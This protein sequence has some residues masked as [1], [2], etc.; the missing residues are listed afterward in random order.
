ME[1]D[2]P[3][4]RVT[5]VEDRAEDEVAEVYVRACGPLIGLLTVMGGSASEAEEVAQEAF[6]RLLVNW[7]RVREYDDIDA[8]LRLVA[9][10]LLV[11]RHRRTKVARLGLGR[12]AA[13]SAQ[14]APE[15][16]PDALDLRQALSALP[17]GSRAVLVLHH[18][19]DLPVSEI[20]SLLRV[21]VGTV[22]SRLA[23]ARAAIAPLLT[24]RTAP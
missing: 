10:R 14:V 8:W 20:A 22:K 16:S 11:S 3:P 12:I 9:V 21:P 1:P 18:V 5:H 13:R 2:R 23:R 6:V 4:P 19:H 24:E 7:S 17:V 15:P